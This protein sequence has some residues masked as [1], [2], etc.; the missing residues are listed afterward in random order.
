LVERYSVG[1]KDMSGGVGVGVGVDVDR[2]CVVVV[3]VWWDNGLK[4]I[5]VCL[6]PSFNISIIATQES[7]FTI[8]S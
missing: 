8:D 3:V 5:S 7:L 6:F 4:G 2:L 1:V